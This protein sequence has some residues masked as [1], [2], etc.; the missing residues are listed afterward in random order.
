MRISIIFH[1]SQVL[2]N[3]LAK[4][5]DLLKAMLRPRV[6]SQLLPDEVLAENG[7]TFSGK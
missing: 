6:H 1:F 5:D 2:L 4:G 3:I 7:T